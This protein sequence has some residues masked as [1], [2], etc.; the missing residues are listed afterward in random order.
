MKRKTE[1]LDQSNGTPEAKKRALMS[2]T[3]VSRFRD[4]LFAPA[5]LDKY[6]KSYASSA[7]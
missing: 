3:V 5:E 4:G 2:A 6:T 1:D 7:P